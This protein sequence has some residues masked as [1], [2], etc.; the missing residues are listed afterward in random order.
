MDN[1][2]IDTR[3]VYG[4][5]E[6]GKTYFIQDCILQDY[7]HKYGTTLILCFEQGEQEYDTDI[8]LEKKTTVVY[9]EGEKD[10]SCFS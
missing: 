3:L 1:Q 5:L 9:Y 6:A 8:L 4:F 2:K 10:I 7:F